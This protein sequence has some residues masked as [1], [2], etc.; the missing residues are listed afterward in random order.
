LYSDDVWVLTIPQAAA[1]KPPICT[2]MRT[3]GERLSI[4]RRL[5]P[6]ARRA[7]WIA[8]VSA[9][10]GAER[11][12]IL[13]AAIGAGKS[14]PNLLAGIAGLW[15]DL[16][17]EA[18]DAAIRA[19]GPHPT[20]LADRVGGTGSGGPA[21]AIA[22]CAR[23]L[24][25]SETD[26]GAARA[27]ASRLTTHLRATPVPGWALDELARACRPD[28]AR[29]LLDEA[30]TITLSR[31]GD[32]RHEPTLLA[33]L[34]AAARPG[35]HLSAWFA[36][37]DDPGH[38]ALRAAV[39]RLPGQSFAEL[40]VPLLG[41]PALAPIVASRLASLD[42]ADAPAMLA[43]GHRLRARGRSATV[44]RSGTRLGGLALAAMPTEA[45]RGA[46]DWVRAAADSPAARLDML[47]QR[48]TD[49]DAGVRLRA[50]RAL[51]DLPPT[52]SLDR[53]LLEFALDRE[54]P[55]ARAAAAMLCGAAGAR[56]RESLAPGLRTLARSP[57]ASVR[58]RAQR[59]LDAL[60]FE[61][62]THGQ[63]IWRSPIAARRALRSDRG[64]VIAE[65]S[66]QML[67]SDIGAALDAVRIVERTGAAAACANTLHR[68]ITTGDARIA[69]TAVRAL[70]RSGDAGSRSALALALTHADARV[71]ANALEELHRGTPAGAHQIPPARAYI[72][73]PTPR[74][75]AN[76]AHALLR[77]DPRDT[78]AQSV[79]GAMLGDPRPAHRRS[80]LW[81]V[82][83]LAVLSLAPAVADI[84]RREPDAEV[85]SRALRCGKRL[86]DHLVAASVRP[87]SPVEALAS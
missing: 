5:R 53:T 23:A 62:G 70:A 66:A 3:L 65:L 74:I 27:L 22:V 37:S 54:E 43:Q 25:L 81:V 41:A 8:A 59:A 68:V 7:A 39:R 32:H 11:A 17:S 2:P 31:F 83:R 15:T 46:L 24:T 84:V 76:A 40:A 10:R 19:A 67:D 9:S 47:A 80:G 13:S 21:L 1:H 30:L 71:R 20:E 64:A 45:R 48:L 78:D 69:A 28:S 50:V 12:S 63:R 26:P 35:P 49:P 61:I 58:T 85:R 4:L 82:E 87:A 55:V 14:D 33:A 18:R 29:A 6:A 77:R 16:P 86:L 79:V 72:D 44:R 36:S 38:F 73:D 75:R 51:G 42:P 34:R 57:H 56:R 60:G 52:P